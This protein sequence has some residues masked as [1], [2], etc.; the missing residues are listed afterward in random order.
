MHKASN[1]AVFRT[2]ATRPSSEKG[3]SSSVNSRPYS[4]LRRRPAFLLL[5]IPVFMLARRRH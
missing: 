3:I 5:L 2:C 4:R 1:Y